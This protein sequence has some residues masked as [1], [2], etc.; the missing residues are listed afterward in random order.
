[1][2]D[3][4]GSPV[5]PAPIPNDSK[6]FAHL[7]ALIAEAAS[8]P[9]VAVALEGSRSYGV[10]LARTLTE[11]GLLVIECEQPGRKQRRGKGKSDEPGTGSG[12]QS[13]LFPGRWLPWESCRRRIDAGGPG[14]VNWTTRKPLS[15]PK[16]ASSSQTGSAA[17]LQL[18]RRLRAIRTATASSLTRVR[19]ACLV[20]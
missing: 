4:T 20:G 10:G 7:V 1:M 5:L 15:N 19:S 14:G 16:S 6:G 13:Q 17:Q 18:V 11:A 2:P 3:T 8:C 9:Q 12:G